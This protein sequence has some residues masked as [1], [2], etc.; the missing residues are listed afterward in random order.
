MDNHL[1]RY[2]NQNNVFIDLE[3]FNLCLSFHH[4]R[5]WQAAMIKTEN[6]KPTGKRDIYVDWWKETDLDISDD[7][8]RITKFNKKKVMSKAIPS[9]EAF[10]QLSEWLDEADYIIGHNIIGFDVY[11]IKEWYQYE[12]KDWSHLAKKFIDTNCIAKAY[13]MQ[14]LPSEGEDL[15]E[16]QYKMYHKRVRGLK[17]NQT[18]LGKEFKIDFDYDSLHDALNDIELNIEI[19]K[20]LKWRIEI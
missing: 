10:V 8:A 15:L 2:Q 13:K 5:P 4:N 3:T 11:L 16:F 7:A 14:T 20:Q 9:P 6:D 1:I 18:A 17:T 12:K 19:W